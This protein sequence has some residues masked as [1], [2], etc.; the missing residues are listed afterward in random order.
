M[1]YTAP[2]KGKEER[3]KERKLGEMG[4]S[5]IFAPF[6]FSLEDR[7]LVRGGVRGSF[8]FFSFGAGKG[9]SR[10]SRLLTP[11]QFSRGAG[12]LQLNLAVHCRNQ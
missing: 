6:L 11:F 2:G 8:R 7:W 10:K 9:L 1:L 5:S 12:D 3:I 4:D